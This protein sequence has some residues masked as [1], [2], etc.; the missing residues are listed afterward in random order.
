[1]NRISFSSVEYRSNETIELDPISQP[2]ILMTSSGLGS[3]T[4]NFTG[5]RHV[6]PPTEEIETTNEMLKFS[7]KII[8]ILESHLN[9]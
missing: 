4:F 9:C 7:Y 1:M 5:K 8:Y 3:T 2:E 6:V